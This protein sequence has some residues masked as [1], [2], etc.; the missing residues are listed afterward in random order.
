MRVRPEQRSALA[1]VTLPAAATP[2]GKWKWILREV[3]GLLVPHRAC[4]AAP[5]TGARHILFARQDERL[6][7]PR[8]AYIESVAVDMNPARREKGDPPARAN[9]RQVA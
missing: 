1:S 9:F 8:R 4:S 7:V 5:S 3:P 6:G 2:H